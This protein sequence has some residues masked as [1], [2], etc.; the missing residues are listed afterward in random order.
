MPA[1]RCFPLM[2]LVTACQSAAP[3]GPA[4]RSPNPG[5]TNGV[6]KA[7]LVA[8]GFEHPWGLAILPDGRMLVTERPGRLRLV[9]RDGRISEPLTGIPPVYAQGQGGLLDVGL[10]PAFATN[11]LVYLSYAEADGSAA[12]TVWHGAYSASAGSATCA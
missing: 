8:R 3:Q 12:G 1:R 10:D 4:M 2:L 6:V 7:E 5:Y 11:H 9:T